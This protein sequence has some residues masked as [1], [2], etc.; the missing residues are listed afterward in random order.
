MKHEDERKKRVEIVLEE[1]KSNLEKHG[2]TAP[3]LSILLGVF[4]NAQ[5]AFLRELNKEVEDSEIDLDY[6]N[7]NYISIRA[8]RHFEKAFIQMYKDFA[9]DGVFAGMKEPKLEVVQNET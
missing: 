3:T 9:E 7:K 2:L 8:S 4:H 6:Y 1:A 5:L